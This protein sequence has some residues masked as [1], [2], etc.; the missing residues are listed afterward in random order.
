MKEK[1]I[2]IFVC[3]LLIAV[4]VLPVAG[5]V[6]SDNT[7]NAIYSSVG[8]NVYVLD[9]CDPD[10]VHPPFNDTLTVIDGNSHV[11]DVVVTGFNIAQTIGGYKA[12]KACRGGDAC[13]VIENVADQ[14][15]KYD[16][17]GNMVF[18][19]DDKDFTCVDES[20]DGNI[21]AHIGTTIHGD[22]IAIINSSGV[23]INE[24]S[25]GN[26]DLVVDDKRGTVWTVGGDLKKLDKD[27]NLQFSIDPFQWAAVS[28]DFTSDGDVWVAEARHT[29]VPGSLNRLLKISPTGVILEIVNL[30]YRPNCLSVNRNDNTFWLASLNNGG[31]AKYDSDGNKLFAVENTSRK[32][33]VVNQVDNSVWVAGYGDVKHYSPG[34][35]L[36]GSISGFSS[37]HAWI[38]LVEK[39]EPPKIPILKLRDIKGGVLGI[40]VELVNIGK[41]TAYDIKW[42]MNLSEIQGFLFYPKHAT[43]EI[44][45]LAPGEETPINI[46]FM[47]GLGASTVKF[48]CDYTMVL[49][50]SRSELDVTVKQ[51]WRDN[52]FFILHSFPDGSQPT[53]EWRTLK[54]H[55]YE[56]T[57]VEDERVVRFELD[58][59]LI[60][61]LHNTRVQ[62]KD[63]QEIT[64][65]GACKMI[66]GEGQL[67]EDWI[68]Q[69]MV[70]SGD[71]VWEVEVVT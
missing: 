36:L 10:F 38:T 34:G 66:Y 67:K 52:G 51:E 11:V 56:Y 30:S 47:F 64:F 55:E 19:L 71:G 48:Y 59:P 13:L 20:R 26:L 15:S 63:T 4:T 49:N 65:L 8:Y 46:G 17:D 3:M 16:K 45:Q 32:S 21:Y 61:Q 35:S 31:L 2:D 22:S 6:N 29:S 53:K 14:L 28:V 7:N 62:I 37:D 41:A 24:K 54:E 69:N 12:I 5:N 18:S 33:V 40:S 60:L 43:G 70:E 42:E 25:Y 50:E 39:R 9:N 27:L 44:D 68:T 58:P 1:I 23:I 57:I